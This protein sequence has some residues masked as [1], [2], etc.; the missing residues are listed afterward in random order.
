MKHHSFSIDV[1][2]LKK[3]VNFYQVSRQLKYIAQQIVPLKVG[4][5]RFCAC[6]IGLL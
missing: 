3:F 4:Y 1:I 2:N 5:S 6:A